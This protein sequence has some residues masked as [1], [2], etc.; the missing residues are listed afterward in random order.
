[1][2]RCILILC[3]LLV[4]T[5][6]AACDDLNTSDD[7]VAR[8]D[9]ETAEEDAA[10]KLLPS[11]LQLFVEREQ[12]PICHRPFG[13]ALSPN[14]DTVFVAC[15]GSGQVAALDT[16]FFDRTWTTDPLHDR[17]FKLLADPRRPRLYAIGMNGGRV[18]VIDTKTGRL[19][20]SLP[21]GGAIADIA[22]VPGRDRLIATVTQPS[23]AVIFDL[24]T[25]T[26]TGHVDFPSP[27]GSL[28]LRPDGGLAAAGS[29][30]WK[31]MVRKSAAVKEPVYLFDPQHPGRILAD[32]GLGGTQTRQPL[33]LADG[34]TLLVPERTSDTVSVF[35]V[36]ERRLIRTIQVGAA[37][38]KLLATPNGRWAFSLDSRGASI[39][40]IDLRR[41]QT[42]GLVVLPTN[43][44]D[45]I[46]SP[47]GI[48]L[49]AALAC[50]DGRQGEIA[51]IDVETATVLDRIQVGSDPCAMTTTHAGRKLIVS[52]FRSDT[53]SILE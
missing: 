14:E 48:Q 21:L 34:R 19:E 42:A 8:T 46:V 28:A 32:L 15:A 20:K 9:P 24:A 17:V 2:R 44:Q 13:L 25:L 5:W 16:E 23:R 18:H 33:F 43:P 52:N 7:P 6:I 10:P 49:Y 40:R 26:E 53:I 41:K 22:L 35:D 38:E 31:R 39:T 47:D 30:L 36:E 12:V 3:L 37:P 29:G 27:P 11:H 4:A 50:R 45:M 1:M 51:V